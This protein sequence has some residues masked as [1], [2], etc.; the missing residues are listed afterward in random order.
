MPTLTEPLPIIIWRGTV[1]NHSLPLPNR[2]PARLLRH[3]PT[4]VEFQ[5]AMLK[6]SASAE[7]LDYDETE[8]VT[9]YDVVITDVNPPNLDISALCPK[10]IG[11]IL[12]LGS[13]IG[14]SVWGREGGSPVSVVAL[15][16]D[17]EDSGHCELYPSLKVLTSSLYTGYRF[18]EI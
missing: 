17:P 6:D 10:R 9:D 7:Q 3:S 12:Y 16:R 1:T 5:L 14:L 18:E 2:H 4:E 11:K 8:W 13:D 15:A